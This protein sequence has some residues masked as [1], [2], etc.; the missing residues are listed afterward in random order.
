MEK[1]VSLVGGLAVVNNSFQ[2]RTPSTVPC[3]AASVVI[4]EAIPPE[5]LA[6]T[7]FC[8][9]Q[10]LLKQQNQSGCCRSMQPNTCL[11]DVKSEEF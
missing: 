10:Y 11:N 5:P 8:L 2:A 1:F 3:L 7:L 9:D 4:H 6:T